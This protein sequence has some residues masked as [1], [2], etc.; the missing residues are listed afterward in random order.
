[1]F[2][3]QGLVVG[4]GGQLRISTAKGVPI[5]LGQGKSPQCSTV[6]GG[7]QATPALGPAF[8]CG[9]SAW[10]PPE[11]LLCCLAAGLGLAVGPG[12]GPICRLMSCPIP[13]PSPSPGRCSMPGAAS[14]AP[15]LS[16]S[17]LGWWDRR[18]YQ[19]LSCQPPWEPPAQSWPPWS[20]QL[21]W[22]S[23]S[24][25]P[26]HVVLSFFPAHFTCYLTK[27]FQIFSVS[28]IIEGAYQLG[29]ILWA[30]SHVVC[31]FVYLIMMREVQITPALLTFSM[32]VG[33]YQSYFTHV[34]CW[35][36]HLFTLF[37]WDCFPCLLMSMANYNP[38]IL[39][40]WKSVCIPSI[41]RWV[42]WSTEIT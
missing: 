16:C 3:Q 7:G 19:A 39:K 12:L 5:P 36:K 21:P 31:G 32:S 29:A 26:L 41:A 22:L 23:D 1:M 18:G 40:S 42:F 10:S 37:F 20:P 38:F 28:W 8:S 15:C 13:S 6:G 25:F 11:P 33:H 27:I 14:S 17:W 35:P 34:G 2:P 24:N 9:P 4:A 30:S